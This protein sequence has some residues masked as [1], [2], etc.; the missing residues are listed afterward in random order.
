MTITRDIEPTGRTAGPGPPEAWR[1][2]ASEVA[3]ALGA[4]L[5]NGLSSAEAAVRLERFGPNRLEAARPVRGPRM[6]EIMA[7]IVNRRFMSAYSGSGRSSSRPG[8]LRPPR[9]EE[10]KISPALPGKFRAGQIGQ[11]WVVG[12][13]IDERP[14]TT[15]ARLRSQRNTRLTP[16][17]SPAV[18]VLSTLF[19]PGT[20]AA[21]LLVFIP[22]VGDYITPTLVGG[23]NGIMIGN[24]VQSQFGKGDASAARG[25]LARPWIT[26][27]TICSRRAYVSRAFLWVFIRL[28]SL[29]GR[30]GWYLP[31]S[32][33]QSE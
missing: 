21:S 19:P 30:E 7:L 23:T 27:R 10:V 11:I 20:I 4:D 6:R 15:S 1:H 13:V 5:R 33:T 22:T 18:H 9:P 25:T 2:E 3:A 16:S 31:V 14:A 24:I 8:W 28:S 29:R 17:V 26:S 32:Q 12:A